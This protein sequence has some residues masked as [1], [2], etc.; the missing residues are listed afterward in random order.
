[1]STTTTNLNLTKP[2][3]NENVDLSVIN[4]NYDIID[5]FAGSV[6]STSDIPTSTSDL[7]NDSNFAVD[8]D[9]VHTDNNY[10][11]TEKTK[12]AGLNTVVAN[13][14]GSAT[15][16]N[17][18]TLQVGSDIYAVPSGGGSGGGHVIENSSGTDMA[19][20]DNLQFIGAYLEDDSTNDR[21]KVN[22]VRHT[23]SAL[24]D[25]MSSSQKEGI[26]VVDDEYDFDSLYMISGVFIDTDNVIV[27]ETAYSGQL[28]YT[29]T[30]DCIVFV[31]VMGTA[32]GSGYVYINNKTVGRTYFT[33]NGVSSGTIH[34]YG[35]Y[36]LLKKGQTLTTATQTFSGIDLQ[37]AVYGLQTSD[38]DLRHILWTELTGTL[39]AGQTTLVISD[40][41]I[42]ADAIIDY[43]TDAFGV[44]PTN[45][46][47][48]PGAITMTFAA[49]QT[50]LGVKVRV[51]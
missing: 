18:S 22:V 34:I 28:S 39:T 40:P 20:E 33:I 9:Y 38:D 3:N 51:S 15:A 32:S 4:G 42:T 43:Y 17:L 27:E 2:A 49:Q 6:P 30:E 11:T 8:A 13:P 47:V 24:Y 31:N 19:Q 25:A 29:A 44:E 21:T 46:V 48:N 5:Q 10:T 7:L 50:D 35:N 23:T 14:S 1:M 26:V 37:Y 45:I 16:G 41:C 12:L 36:Y